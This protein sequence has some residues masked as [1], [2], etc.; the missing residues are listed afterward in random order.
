MRSKRNVLAAAL[1][2]A[3][4]A[5]LLLALLA[6]F[7]GAPQQQV[8]EVRLGTKLA[9]AVYRDGKLVQSVEKRGD[10][11]TVNFFL[12][13]LNAWAGQYNVY[14]TSGALRTPDWGSIT[15][16]S[17]VYAGR[18]PYLRVYFGTGSTSP[19]P[20]DYAL[21]GSVGSADVAAANYQVSDDGN[22]ITVTFSTSWTA[23][24]AYTIQEIGLAVTNLFISGSGSTFDSLIARDV[25]STPLVVAANDVVVASYTITIPYNQA[26]LTRNLAVLLVNYPLGAKYYGKPLSYIDTG[27]NTRTTHDIAYSGLTPAVKLA[28]G[29]GTPVYRA[30]LT[31]LYNTVATSSSTFTVQWSVNATHFTVKLPAAPLTLNSNTQVTEIGFLATNID[32]DDSATTSAT[33]VLVLYQPLSNALSVPAGSGV[34]AGFTLVFPLRPQSAP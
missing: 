32:V 20:Y 10:P 18:Y 34:K 5:A 24:S 12:L 21:A 30:T 11:L 7:H 31:N 19:T 6:P 29:S 3:A 9:L 17:T 15:F 22:Q 23:P 25:L 16:S 1:A 8:A 14:D 33:S 27:G 26:P 2:A 28:V 13:W 4:I